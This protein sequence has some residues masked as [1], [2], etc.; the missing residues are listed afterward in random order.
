MKFLFISYN[1]GERNLLDITNGRKASGVP[2]YLSTAPKPP[3]CKGR[4]ADYHLKC[5]TRKKRDNIA[6]LV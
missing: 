1:F 4:W 2:A 5:N 3:L 6:N